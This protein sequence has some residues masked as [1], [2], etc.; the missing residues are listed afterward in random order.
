MSATKYLITIGKIPQNLSE[1]CKKTID[2]FILN[3]S[4]MAEVSLIA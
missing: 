4:I 2:P 3:L 1:K